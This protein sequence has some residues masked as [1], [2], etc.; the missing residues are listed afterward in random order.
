MHGRKM[1]QINFRVGEWEKERLDELVKKSGLSQT[2]YLLSSTVY[3]DSVSGLN[4][5][6]LQRISDE[7]RAQGVNLNQAM[8]LANT[9]HMEGRDGQARGAIREIVE[10]RKSLEIVQNE[11]YVAIRDARPHRFSPE[12]ATDI[13][14]Y[15]DDD[16]EDEW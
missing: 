2:E 5:E 16:I 6:Q 4:Y 14:S 8:R 11:L 3:A 10:M 12:D 7:L 1:M 15:V 9:L 13:E